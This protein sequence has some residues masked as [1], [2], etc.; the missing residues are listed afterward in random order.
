MPYSLV[1][2]GACNPE[3]PILDKAVRAERHVHKGK[4][5]EDVVDTFASV[6]P[7]KPKSVVPPIGED[8]GLRLR[9]LVHTPHEAVRTTN[10]RY[11]CTICGATRRY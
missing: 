9:E 5:G 4:H 1:C 8:L 11:V 6:I 10:D 7:G 2:E 3:L